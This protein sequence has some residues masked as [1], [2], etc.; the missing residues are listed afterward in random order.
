MEACRQT[1]RKR[2]SAVVETE[3]DPYDEVFSATGDQ[4]AAY[5]SEVWDSQVNQTDYHNIVR[6]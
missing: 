3:V 2:Y 4:L 5:T 6:F 1:K